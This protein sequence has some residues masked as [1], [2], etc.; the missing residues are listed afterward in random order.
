MGAR[1]WRSNLLTGLVVLLDLMAFSAGILRLPALRGIF[2]HRSLDGQRISLWTFPFFDSEAAVC[3]VWTLRVAVV[4]K[5]V[6]IASFIFFLNIFQSYRDTLSLEGPRR[7]SHQILVLSV[8]HLMCSIFQVGVFWR[9]YLPT[10]LF[11]PR[12]W[13]PGRVWY[14]IG[15]LAANRLLGIVSLLITVGVVLDALLV[16]MVVYYRSRMDRWR[17]FNSEFVSFFTERFRP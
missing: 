11:P 3:L 7:S 15:V 5:V 17:K 1:F 8:A 6:L 16:V 10:V 2:W 9:F 4:I 14:W 12:S 13:A